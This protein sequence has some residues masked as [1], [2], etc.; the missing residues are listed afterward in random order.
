MLKK[1]KLSKHSL[2]RQAK[3]VCL[4]YSL[5]FE[6]LLIWT[7]SYG[8]W[9][10]NY[11]TF[12][13]PQHPFNDNKPLHYQ[14]IQ[15]I[16]LGYFVLFSCEI[17]QIRKYEERTKNDLEHFTWNNTFGNLDYFL[18]C[19]HFK[20]LPCSFPE[21]PRART[22]FHASRNSKYLLRS[23]ENNQI[24]QNSSKQSDVRWL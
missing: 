10:M 17:I 16:S 18:N 5:M 4:N 20:T 12:V 23:K 7:M 9:T 15:A 2:L 14:F 3:N 13:Q 24:S 11:W 19:H 6:I 21:D 8:P 22:P 1:K